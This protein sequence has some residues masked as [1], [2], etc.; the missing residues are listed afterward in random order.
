[1]IYIL[2]LLLSAGFALIQCL[3]GGTRMLFSFPS[4]AIFGAAA[5]LSV[6]S[7]RRAISTPSFACL[8]STVLL[9]LWVIARA[10]F[11][12]IP[13]LA[14]PDLTMAAACLLVYLLTALH[15]TESRHRLL[16]L[17]ALF[18]IAAVE[19]GV[20]VVQFG[21]D[22]KFML[23]GFIRP[24]SLERA[25]GM[26]ISGNHFAG[27]L[28]AIAMIALALTV[29]GRWS[30]PARI[31]TGYLAVMCFLGV[32]ISGSRGGYLSSVLGVIALCALSLWMMH[33]IN[34]KKTMTLLVVSVLGVIAV[35]GVTGTVMVQSRLIR[36]RLNRDH[37]H[38]VRLYNWL[39]AI[40]QFRLSP[41]IG[42]GAGTHL[43]YGRH[44]RRPP[45]Q[46]DPVHAHGDYL[47]MLAEYGV[48]GEALALIFLGA[49][50]VNGFSGARQIALRRL[51]FA[52]E[53]PTSDA[54][55]L[56]LGAVCAVTALM[57]H[58]VVDFNMHIPGNALLFAF[59][60]GILSNP[61]VDRPSGQPAWFSAITALRLALL[62]AGAALIAFTVPKLKGE[63]LSEE[64]RIA[65]RNRKYS[66]VTE[67]A[68][69]AIAA[70]PL[71][72]TNY[73]YLG[74]AYRAIGLSIGMPAVRP[75]YF[76][77]ALNAYREGLKRFPQDENLMVR[78]AQALDGLRRFEEAEAAYQ[79]AMRWDPNLGLI[80][81]YYA[82]HLH[83]LGL[84]EEEKKV[85]AEAQE[86]AN[87]DV[88]EVGVDEVH[89]L[90]VEPRKNRFSIDQE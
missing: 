65:L 52:I 15:L 43:D 33:L 31:L 11:S 35:V 47:E 20:G 77:Q 56:N 25:S 28:E 75:I 66:E 22:N 89:A 73:F 61:A 87:G 2:L 58:S 60:F 6:I 36:E 53:R 9:A 18:A 44:F 26:F 69:K 78:S 34:P 4:Y 88:S 3:I 50:L 82:S 76:E 8:L 72:Y 67:L 54:L 64:A 79:S 40:D 68:K 86:L 57:A 59:L 23:F 1:M 63:Q 90:M 62:P 84:F 49:H 38:D 70:E 12:P 80:K 24:D 41:W 14:W 17:I 42:T 74:E 21:K 19:I 5:I 45:V 81:A 39:A 48:V 13:Y 71:N 27:F 51:R 29:W 10:W 83:L 16:V 85:R 30:L 55:A 46:A 7:I 32:I 37:A